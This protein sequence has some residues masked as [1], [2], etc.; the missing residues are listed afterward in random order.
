MVL[1]G[2]A[3]AVPFRSLMI[4]IV[5]ESVRRLDPAVQTKRSL[6][7]SSKALLAQ[8]GFGPLWHD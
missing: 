5:A 4:E 6:R 7:S 8:L 3:E 1:Y 2:T